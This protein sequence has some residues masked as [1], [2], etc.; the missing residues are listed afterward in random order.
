MDRSPTEEEIDRPPAAAGQHPPASPADDGEGRRRKLFSESAAQYTSNIYM[1]DWYTSKMWM[2]DL[3]FLRDTGAFSSHPLLHPVAFAA[4]FGR[5]DVVEAMLDKGGGRYDRDGAD[6][7]GYTPIHVAAAKGRAAVVTFLLAAGAD[8][9]RPN[10][11]G[12]SPLDLAVGLGKVDAVKAFIEHGA[13]LLSVK[14]VG[15]GETALHLAAG[16]GQ[17]EVVSLLCRVGGVDANAVNG[18]GWTPL[19]MATL[20]G[21]PGTVRA[22]LAAGADAGLVCGN[23]SPIGLAA[24]RGHEDVLRAI[25]QHVDDVNSTCTADGQAA[26]HVAAYQS[27]PWVFEILIGAG[28]IVDRRDFHGDTPLCI[29]ASH[30]CPAAVTV[31]L[32]HGANVGTKGNAGHAALHMAAAKAGT[33]ETATVVDLL[34]RWG[35]DENSAADDGRTPADV[36]GSV[37]EEQDSIA[38]DVARV[39]ELLANA[40]ADRSWRRRGFLVLCRAHYPGGRVR[41]RLECERRDGVVKRTR[42]SGR[43]EQSRAEDDWAGVASMLMGVG[44]DPV[45]LMGDGADIIFETIVGFL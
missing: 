22:L 3:E 34:L 5:V 24:T 42:S 31:L 6:S 13:D 45:S 7:K 36:I 27:N 21:E 9:A 28:A 35:A 1:E 4:E 32:N 18:D 19:H 16:N 11:R 39:R 20:K 2:E 26:L 17:A 43:A 40:P 12:L 33:A 15:N 23:V 8:A 30:S 29:A 14:H 41:L 38:E 10:D 44:S 37:V 25:L